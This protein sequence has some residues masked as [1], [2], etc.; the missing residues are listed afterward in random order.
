MVEAGV[1]KRKMGNSMVFNMWSRCGYHICF[2]KFL[3]M[4]SC[5]NPIGFPYVDFN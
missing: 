5:W 2:F 3:L 4:A 1:I